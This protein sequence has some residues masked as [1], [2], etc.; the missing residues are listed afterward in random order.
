MLGGRKWLVGQ[1]LRLIDFKGE[2]KGGRKAVSARGV[3]KVGSVTGG[4]VG[5]GPGAVDR[6][7][8]ARNPGKS[9]LLL[10]ATPLVKLRLRETTE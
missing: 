10:R 5:H 9:Q 8:S 6:L 1:K 7:A 4:P 2:G 3:G